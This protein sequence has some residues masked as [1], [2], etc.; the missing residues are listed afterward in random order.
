MREGALGIKKGSLSSL[1][2]FRVSCVTNMTLGV[3]AYC[4]SVVGGGW[5]GILIFG[6]AFW[7]FGNLMRLADVTSFRG[8]ES[9]GEDGR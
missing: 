8:W 9:R 5:V 7:G 6:G 2:R 4:Y 3:W 1:G